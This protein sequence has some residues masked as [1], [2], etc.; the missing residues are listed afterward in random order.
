MVVVLGQRLEEGAAAVAQ[1]G[2][3]PELRDVDDVAQL[4]GEENEGCK[5]MVKHRNSKGAR[6]VCRA[7]SSG[8]IDAVVT[9]V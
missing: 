3:Q 2:V 6:R 9:A 4:R 5:D 7:V 8:K 1:A